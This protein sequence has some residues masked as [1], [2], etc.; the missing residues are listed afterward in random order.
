MLGLWRAWS[1]HL[2]ASYQSQRRG[3]RGYYRMTR[4]K[5]PFELRKGA[6]FPGAQMMR[7]RL[8]QMTNGSSFTGVVALVPLFAME[9]SGSYGSPPRP[10]IGWS[11]P[12]QNGFLA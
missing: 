11:S 3:A 6:T 8:F 9:V 12:S 10:T 7:R 5:S 1:R 4:W 2:I